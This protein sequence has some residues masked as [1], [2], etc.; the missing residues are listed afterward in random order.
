SQRDRA[1]HRH[2]S[3]RRAGLHPGPP[4]PPWPVR[5]G[6]AAPL[7]TAGLDRALL[8]RGGTALRRAA[9]DRRAWHH[10]DLGRRRAGIAA[11]DAEPLRRGR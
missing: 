5:H 2:D 10:D 8:P 9:A 6:R 1:V 7:R 11:R 4:G 3:G